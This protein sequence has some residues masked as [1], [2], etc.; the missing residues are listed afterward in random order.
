MKENKLIIIILTLL[1]FQ[2]KPVPAIET[3]S[4]RKINYMERQF[5]FSAGIISK[6]MCA[7]SLD[8]SDI[9]GGFSILSYAWD[10]YDYWINTN[11]Y[12][13][14]CKMRLELSADPNS[15]EVKLFSF[16]YQNI[17]NSRKLKISSINLPFAYFGMWENGSKNSTLG[18]G[19]GFFL[20]GIKKI[21][22]HSDFS[23][24]LSGLILPLCIFNDQQVFAGTFWPKIKIRYRVLDFIFEIFGYYSFEYESRLKPEYKICPRIQIGT[25]GLINYRRW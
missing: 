7:T 15:D 8:Y 21:N 22:T 10:S 24:E 19:T 17:Y 23:Y 18:L 6:N 1:A 13:S 2:I 11:N 14:T 9:P 4:T 12:R 20:S 5:T 25:S 16:T 3:D